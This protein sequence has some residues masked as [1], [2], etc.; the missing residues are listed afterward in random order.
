LIIDDPMKPEEAA[1]DVRRQFANEWFSQSIVPRLDDKQRGRIILIMQR[2][3]KEDMTGYVLARGDWTHV[4]LPAIAQEDEL[5]EIATPF[6]L[7]RHR[8]REG[9]ALHP[10][11]EP[12]DELAKLRIAM[13]S[14]FF[15]A[16]YLQM[17][18][19]PGGGLVKIDWFPRFDLEH[20]PLFDRIVQ[21]WDTAVSSKD[22]SS[23]SVCTSWGLAAR[24]AYLIHVYRN[25]L[26][27]PDLRR[28]VVAQ[29]RV[30]SAGTVL[31]EDA[32]SGASLLQDLR[33]ELSAVRGCK[34]TGDKI[35]RM[36]AQTAHIENCVVYLPREAPW[37]PDLVHEL[38]MFPKGRY[39]DQ[40]DSISQALDFIFTANAQGWVDYYDRLVRKSKGGDHSAQAPR[41]VKAVS[42]M[43]NVVL[44]VNSGRYVEPD[45]GG[46]YWLTE[47]EAQGVRFMPD[48][49]ILP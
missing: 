10:D 15:S 44:K 22:L 47:N 18:T 29:A 14:A 42:S 27:Y 9:E 19:P 16:Q 34:P 7:I 3:H 11:R 32:A 1:S 39:A 17:P 24:K 31:I 41:N 20:S 21:S 43:P 13:G 40:V 45:S 33:T 49:T 28:A 37:L 8:R 5:H 12:L 23:Y 25:R 35:M 36:N 48:M 4:S 30:F 46:I 26:E 2:L 6:G 38:T